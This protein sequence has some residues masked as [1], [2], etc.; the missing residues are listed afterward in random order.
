MPI[1]VTRL[2]FSWPNGDQVL[3]DLS[4]S[5]QTDKKYGLVGP[6]GVGKSTL[7]KLIAGKL[8]SPAG[9][10]IDGTI[11][12][13]TITRDVSIAYFPQIETPPTLT[14]A[15]YLADLW[16]YA[17]PHEGQIIDSFQQQ[18]DFSR[19]CE[20]LSGGEWTRVRLLHQ[21][22][23]GAD[24]II[25]D[26]PTNNLDR[27]SRDSII[28]F[29]SLT[30]RGL[31]I[32]SHDPE[33][34]GH[35]NIILELST[36]GLTIFGG[37]WSFYEAESTRERARLHAALENAQHE[38]E[39]VKREEQKKIATQERRKQQGEKTSSK[40]GLPTLIAGTRKRTAE[41]TLG[42]VSKMAS[43]RIDAAVQQARS[44]FEEL[45]EDQR[46]Y[47]QF[48]A[49]KIH[50]SKLVFEAVGLN[51][52]YTDAAKPLWAQPISYTMRGPTRLVI[53]GNNGAG[54]TTFV[55]LLTGY[56]K[57]PGQITGT[58]RLGELAYSFIDQQTSILE[59]NKT[60]FE[61]VSSTSKEPDGTIRNLLAQFLFP[62]DKANQLVSTLSGGERL[63][64]ALA[65]ALLAHP[66]PQLLI[67]DEPTNNL[68]LVNRDF[69]IGALKNYEGAL[70]VISH[71]R[72]FLDAINITAT[73]NL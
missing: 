10:I 4:F 1:T 50:A 22:A 39:R 64:A 2:S 25:L 5:L 30:R 69:L 26:E 65:K 28:Q 42:K 19:S 44:A 66:T 73:L 17:A 55:Q 6:N 54:K 23:L 32:I 33:L 70:I 63:R 67:L 52:T 46:M 51:F 8:E 37:N 21:I 15:E 29:V 41:Q 49:A 12:D 59:A 27:T 56:K 57:C 45:K 18:I 61:A 36:Q 34:L 9:T 40:G 11:I 20:S 43:S 24:F 71:D 72:S 58:I 68:D 14:V 53:A 31:L 13:G 62:G 48:P 3:T 35:V 16:L 7:A 38:R 47:A 60:I